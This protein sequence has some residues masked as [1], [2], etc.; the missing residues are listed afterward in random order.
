MA[1]AFR[2]GK[3]GHQQPRSRVAG[4]R[5]AGAISVLLLLFL[6]VPASAGTSTDAT[7]RAPETFP[8]IFE[9]NAGQ[10]DPA[11]KFLSRGAGYTLF[12]TPTETVFGFVTSPPHDAA[13]LLRMKLVGANAQPRIT[14]REELP[15]KVNYFVG[16]DA[17]QW[18]TNVPTYAKVRYESIYPGVDLIYYGYQRRFEYDFIVAPGAD[19]GVITLAFEGPEQLAVDAQGDLVFEI[20]GGELRMRKPLV[21]QEADGSRKLVAANYVLKNKSR[22][23]VQVA[24]Y[25]RTRPLIIDPVLVYSTYVGGSGAEIAHGIAPDPATPGIV[26]VAGETTSTNFPT[27]AASFQP[28]FGKGTDCF[29]A[30]FDTNQNGP[31]SRVY[32]TYLGGSGTDQCYGVAVDGFRNAYVVG[33]TTSTNFPLATK[34]NGNNRGGSDAIVVK[35]NAGGSALLYSVYLGGSADEWGFGIAVDSLGQA[36]VTG[37]TTSTNFPVMG[38]FQTALGDPSGDAFITKINAAGNA[39]LYSSYLGG[40]GIDLGQAI[41]TDPLRAGVAYVTGDTSS[42][43]LPTTNGFQLTA[44]GNGDAFVAKVD[45]TKTGSASLLYSTYVG[46]SGADHG[47]GITT[48]G[49]SAYVTGQTASADLFSI[50]FPP[51]S[52]DTQLAGPSDAFVARIDTNQS[53][54]ALVAFFTYLGGGSDDSGNAIAV[55]AIGDVYVTGQTLGSGFPVTVDAFQPGPGGNGDAFVVRLNTFANGPGALIFASYLGGNGSDAGTGIAL[56]SSGDGYVTGSTSSTVFP[57]TPGGFQTSY[58]GGTTDAFVARIVDIAK[59]ADVSITKT[60]PASVTASSQFS[61]TLSV[62]NSGPNTASTVIVKDTLPAGVTLVSASG[63]GWTCVG[64]TTVTCTLASNLAAGNAP[65][66]LITVKAPAAGATLLNSA[67]VSSATP[68]LGLSN[69][70]SAT[71]QTTVVPVVPPPQADLSITKTGPASVN[72]SSTITYTLSVSNAGPNTASNVSVSDTLP[73]GVTLV[74]AGGSGWT[75]VGTTTVTCTLASLAVGGAPNIVISVT[76]PAEGTTLAN[77]ASVSSQTS[78]PNMTNN[79]SATVQTAVVPRADLSITKTGPASA[80]ASNT[81]TYTL[82]VSN[83]GPSTASAVSVSDTLPAGATLL[84]ASGSGWS[85]S[86]ASTVTCTLA[87]LAVGAAS[88]IVIALTAP[89]V[90]GAISNQASVSSAI[91]DANTGNNTSA[92]VQTIVSG[93]PVFTGATS[94]QVNEG[95]LLTFQVTATDPGGNPLTFSVGALPQGASFNPATQTFAWTPTSAQGGPSPYLAYFTANDGLF[96]TT[97]PVA[98]TVVDIIADRDGDGVP[99]AVD[100]CPDTYNPDQFD[101]CH[102]SPNAVTAYTAIPGS[103]AITGPLFVN[104]TVTFD[105]GPNGTYVLPANLFN[106][107]CRVTDNASGLRL[108]QGGVPE[109]PPINLSVNGD[110]VFVPAGSSQQFTTTFDLRLFYPNLVAGSYTVDCDHV[111]FAHIPLPAADDPTIWRGV[112]GAPAQM[113]SSY[114]FS[115][116]SPV[117]HQPFNQGRTVPVK[118]SLKDSTG[119]FVST[120]I[121]TLTVQRLDS[122][123]QPLGSPIPATPNSGSG[124]VAQYNSATN[125]YQYNMSTDTLIIGPW[126]VQ[127]HL[128]TD[129][130]TRVIAIVIR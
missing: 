49:V 78:D 31:A 24:A 60:G 81:I 53:G 129:N 75:C 68:D 19:P 130:T 108:P 36:Y 114:A 44:G 83:A 12:L 93:P 55:D 121:C 43:N 33:R 21:Y 62:S 117:D 7:R 70:T 14:G 6:L 103:T 2:R 67:S 73:G 65:T 10:T 90:G 109:G 101:V 106:S 47:R 51:L 17:A 52:F 119:A 26:Y 126:L 4:A 89:A 9:L 112:V 61:Y 50:L 1:F 120:C 85:C 25:D 99:D 105:G 72:A 48:D 87:S 30:K 20:A 104:F 29:V 58:G 100:N 8:L 54:Q 63:S 115:F 64:T 124:N 77:S 32:S 82:S 76:G 128:S 113:V 86:G 94:Y 57:T 84:S 71:V 91:S 22:V 98:I 23:G 102:N 15:G 42:T 97:A 122:N 125:Q 3:A 66:I 111:N 45:T 80:N 79:T 123:G 35:L 88:D 38:G 118:F 116:F 11:V 92:T 56:D 110:L 13:G 37:Q 74:S 69:N 18:R 41:V 28:A 95:A 96:T 39:F 40:N 27:T 59:T 34:L 127:V 5:S 16:S 107:I 46:G